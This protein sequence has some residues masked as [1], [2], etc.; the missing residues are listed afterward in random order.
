MTCPQCGTLNGNERDECIRCKQKL[1][2]PEM[3]GK[4]ACSNH[5]NREATTSCA[6]CGVRLCQFCAVN[7]GGVD[8]CDAHAPA[9]ALRPSYDEDY[10]RVPVVDLA[11]TA[12]AGFGPR[13][14]A[15]VI[16]SLVVF[17]AG[18]IIAML[19]WL[20]VGSVD[21]INRPDLHPGAY[22]TY[23]TLLVLGTAA[24]IV[25]LT[26]MNG[27]TLGKQ[28]AGV[29]IL[30]RDGRVI[31]LQTSLIRYAVSLVSLGALGLGFLW[32]LWDPNKETWHDKAARTASFRF[33]E[34]A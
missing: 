19:F 29:I 23:W 9:S 30:Q 1:R 7:A 10:E 8:F 13:L 26:A 4:I 20:L 16:D 28:I 24:Y 15:F 31:T 17:A 25:V 34:S 3:A 11:T 14:L 21:F 2:S 12:R 6:A 22:G 32:A 27:Q 18:V 5:G 33:E